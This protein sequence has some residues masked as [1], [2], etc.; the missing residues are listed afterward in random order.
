MQEGGL[1]GRSKDRGGD[2]R[3]DTLCPWGGKICVLLG[4][5]GQ[6][7]DGQTRHAEV[8]VELWALTGAGCRGW[9]GGCRALGRT[10]GGVRSVS[11]TRAGQGGARAVPASW[12]PQQGSAG[13]RS[14]TL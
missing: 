13:G 9:A 12:V 6:Q 11:S 7:M 8:G 3:M 10:G 2:G 14:V 1:A 5:G 4:W